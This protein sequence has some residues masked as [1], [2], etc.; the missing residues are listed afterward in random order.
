M[1]CGYENQ[2]F[3]AFLCPAVQQK[4]AELLFCLWHGLQS[5]P[6]GDIFLV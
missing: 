4:T 2:A 1:T 5:A 6:A 3:Q